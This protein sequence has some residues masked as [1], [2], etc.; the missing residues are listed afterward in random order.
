MFSNRHPHSSS[1]DDHTMDTYTSA[2]EPIGMIRDQATGLERDPTYAEALKYSKSLPNGPLASD[3]SGLHRCRGGTGDACNGICRTC[4]VVCP[5]CVYNCSCCRGCTQMI[6][7][8]LG[9]PIPLYSCITAFACYEEEEGAFIS[10][11]KNRQKACALMPLDRATGRYGVYMAQ[12]Q[13][14][15]QVLKADSQPACIAEP[16]CRRTIQII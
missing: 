12:C 2:P 1:S 16:L 10:R 14:C 15:Q 7:C 4:C 8:W 11:D 3:F 9:V 13:N 5:I 6:W